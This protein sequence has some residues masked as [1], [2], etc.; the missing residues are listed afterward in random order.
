[1]TPP[2]LVVDDHAVISHSLGD[3]LGRSGYDV[4][5]LDVAALD[6]TGIVKAARARGQPIVLLDLHLG[7][8]TSVSVIR[9]LVSAGCTVVLLT[10][11]DD[12]GLIGQAVEAGAAGVIHKSEPFH[13]LVEAIADVAAGRSILGAA[14]REELIGSARRAR[15][16]NTRHE[17]VLVE[18]TEAE[19]A[20]LARLM[21]GDGVDEIA[22]RRSVGVETV[23]SQ[24]KAILRKL[25]ARNQVQALAIARDAGFDPGS[26]PS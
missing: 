21:L 17:S 13:E 6:D 20:V 15:E 16:E 11:S 4:D 3:A 19:R 1:M 8:R 18:L 9:P 2:I 23:R 7:D 25:G 10:A 22:A 5:V 12:E 24:V 14:R 26:S